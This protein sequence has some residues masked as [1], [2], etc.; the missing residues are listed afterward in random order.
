[1]VL[2][3]S[4]RD[5]SGP[6]GLHT[7]ARELQTCTF[8]GPGASNTTKIPRKDPQEREKERKWRRERGK[9][10]E[11]LGPA[12]FGAPPEGPTLRGPI[13]LGSSH[14][15]R[16]PTVRAP[17]FGA[18]CFWEALPIRGPDPGPSH[19]NR[20]PTRP[21]T[22]KHGVGQTWFGQTWEVGAGQTWQ[23]TM[24]KLCFGQSW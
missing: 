16:G 23:N 10:S 24:A 3:A 7:T 5:A 13:F 12:P 15:F 21:F 20:P 6:S 22:L 18:S 14:P 4:L 19:S 8:Q 17:I 2:G 11:I 1:M 9:K